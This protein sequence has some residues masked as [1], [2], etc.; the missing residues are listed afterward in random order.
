VLGLARRD[1]TAV[2]GHEVDGEQVIDREAPVAGKPADTAAEGEA[3]DPDVRAVAERDG[4]SLGER[5][6]HEAAGPDAGAR[7]PDPPLR[8][9]LDRVEPG[10]V[11]QDAALG[12]TVARDRVAAASDRELGAGLARE[13]DRPDDVVLAR[14]ADD[15]RRATV[16]GGV[17]D[18]A[19][20]VVAVVVG[21]Q[22]GS[23]E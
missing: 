11:E 3:A 23:V 14:R 1:A 5:G 17:D 2:G 21:Q 20:G 4:H 19:G 15:D 6:L 7:R 22:D 13:R 18:L 8:V 16:H 9:D 12:G 10:E